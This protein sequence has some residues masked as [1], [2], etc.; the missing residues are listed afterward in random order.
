MDIQWSLVIFTTLAGAG[1]WLAGCIGLNELLPKAKETSTKLIAA[2]VSLVLVVAGGLVSVTHLSHPDRIMAALGH[3]T[4]G[5]FMEALFVGLLS[6]ALIVFIVMLKRQVNTK[7]VGI[8][9]GIIG[10]VMTF[11]LG[12][13]YMM[14]SRPAWNTI[15]LPLTYMFTAAPPGIGIWVA[16]CAA[17]SE[18]AATSF[19]ATLLAIAG[20]LSAVVAALYSVVSG[21]GMGACALLLWGLTVFAG[22]VLPAVCGF[23]AMKK[24]EQGVMLGSIAAILAVVGC[25]G[26]RCAMWMV[27]I[28][29]ENFF[30]LV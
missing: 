16:L 29:I 11:V 4:S 25:I 26:F 10:L 23:M 1:A 18:S 9:V 28:G 24:P 13:S 22:G 8:I 17:K 20:A 2:I 30:G 19:A 5:I 21:A 7:V 15:L 14:Y 3:P 12:Y 6:L 27:G